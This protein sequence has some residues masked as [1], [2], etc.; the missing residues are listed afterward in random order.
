MEK[1]YNE[2]KDFEGTQEKNSTHY[3][4][5]NYIFNSE[6]RTTFS[7]QAFSTQ[8]RNMDIGRLLLKFLE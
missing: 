5:A 2:D 6:L 7:T 3:G 1:D 4:A 8:K